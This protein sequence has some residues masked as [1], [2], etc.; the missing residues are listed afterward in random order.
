M[1]W[2]TVSGGS[3]TGRVHSV[4][5]HYEGK[6]YVC[7]GS[8]ENGVNDFSDLHKYD[9]DIGFWTD[10]TSADSAYL[11]LSFLGGTAYNDALYLF[12][13]WRRDLS[14]DSESVYRMSL[15][16]AT[17]RWELVSVEG[18]TTQAKS[19][20]YAFSF[21]NNKFYLVGGYSGDSALLKND[22]SEFDLSLSPVQLSY[23]PSNNVPLIRINHSFIS[24]SGKLYLFGGEANE[25][26]MN[27]LWSYDYERD[28]WELLDTE[29][30]IP[31]PRSHHGMA[32][33]GSSM[34]V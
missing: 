15:S 13:G 21:N 9:L 32:A 22:F 30:E 27:D 18:D 25:N 19:D 34:I 3:V 23:S 16:D 17:F 24:M 7:A 14:T 12:F 5:S 33:E 28:K 29:G 31:A 6:L 11:P 1:E 20:S 26:K 10:M 2:S 8:D 4:L